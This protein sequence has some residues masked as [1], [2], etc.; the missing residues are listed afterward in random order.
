[1]RCAPNT[2]CFGSWPGAPECR[3]VSWSTH[4]QQSRRGH[5]KR[6]DGTV[7]FGVLKESM[8]TP[9]C[10]VTD[11]GPI[12][13]ILH[14]TAGSLPLACGA[15]LNTV[16]CVVANAQAPVESILCYHR[17]PWTWHITAMPCG[18]EM[19]HASGATG[20]DSVPVAPL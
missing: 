16:R 14:H 5:Q 12:R 10:G 4:N 17:V 6:H 3:E 8:V 2:L 15:A 18:T 9:H 1:M 19:T 13:A 20:T 7:G 11:E